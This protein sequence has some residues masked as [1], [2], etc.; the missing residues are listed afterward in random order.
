MQGIIILCCWLSH[1]PTF[2]VSALV[3]HLLQLK[4]WVGWFVRLRHFMHSI[5]MHFLSGYVPKKS[6]GKWQYCY[7]YV[8]ILPLNFCIKLVST[9]RV[10]VY[11]RF[12]VVAIASI[13][14]LPTIL[15]RLIPFAFQTWNWN[16]QDSSEWVWQT[17]EGADAG[18]FWIEE[19]VPANETGNGGHI[20]YKEPHPKAGGIHWIHRSGQ[21]IS[22]V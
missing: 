13:L 20:K 10:I 18:K 1:S 3:K 15:S 14:F 17:P 7:H 5:Q 19:S 16:V 12:I 8:R 22:P 4:K 6:R 2:Y 9:R 11:S 21:S